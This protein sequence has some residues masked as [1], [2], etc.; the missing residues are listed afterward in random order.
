MISL[1]AVMLV[2]MGV[3]ALCLS[4]NTAVDEMGTL[5]NA[6]LLSGRNWGTGVLSNGGFYYRYGMALVWCIPFF[7]LKKGV[8]IYK[9]VSLINALLMSVTPVISYYIARRYL[10]NS[11][12]KISSTSGSSFDDD[13]QCDVPGDLPERRCYADRDELGMY[14]VDFKY[15]VCGYEKKE[16]P[17]Y[18]LVKLCSSICICKPQQRDCYCDSSYNSGCFSFTF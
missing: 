9:A 12:R 1:F 6:A 17:V 15:Y 2:L 18:G 4:T 14:I 16:M 8:Q 3:P 10:K 7:L 11:K 13:Q 5:A